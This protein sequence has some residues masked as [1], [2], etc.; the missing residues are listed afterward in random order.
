[1]FWLVSGTFSQIIKRNLVAQGVCLEYKHKHS[2]FRFGQ[3][4]FLG[5]GCHI[6]LKE[7]PWDS[8]ISLLPWY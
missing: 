8:L 6:L 4:S 5:V 1:M 7:Q 2:E 3:M